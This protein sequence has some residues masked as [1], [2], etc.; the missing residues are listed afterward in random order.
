MQSMYRVWRDIFSFWKYEESSF[1]RVENVAVTDDKMKSKALATIRLQLDRWHV[2][3]GVVAENII[4]SLEKI[5]GF[6]SAAVYIG[7]IF[8]AF[9]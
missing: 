5:G 8:V 7:F 1:I 2:Y 9:F 6:A 3:Y 4:V